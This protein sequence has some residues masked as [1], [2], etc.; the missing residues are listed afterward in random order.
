MSE[1]GD[2]QRGM[3]QARRAE[4]QRQYH[5]SVC[6]G[7]EGYPTLVAAYRVRQRL[8]RRGRRQL[9]VYRCPHCQT[10]H[11]CTD[12]LKQREARDGE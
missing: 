1:R 11:L 2:G 12:R 5:R 4:Q 9:G 3:V 10:W 7:K 8:Q 6:A